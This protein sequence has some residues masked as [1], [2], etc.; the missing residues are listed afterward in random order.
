MIPANK[1][2]WFDALFAAYVRSKLR[3]T[4]HTV[5]V[6]GA[7][8][9]RTLG[10]QAPLLLVSNHT[11]WW[12]PLI[13]IALSRFALDVDGHAMMDAKNLAKLPFFRRVGAFGVDRD[14]PQDG[15]R[16]IRYAAKL[17]D[18]PR[19]MVWIFAQGRERPVTERPLV[20]F[21][22]AAETARIARR[23]AVVPVALR[24]EHGEAP[25]PSVWVSFGESIVRA[26]ERETEL[27]RRSHEEAVTRELDRIDEAIRAESREGFAPLWPTRRSV[28]FETAQRALALLTGR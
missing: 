8:K 22:G 27:T 24:Y 20:F 16:A 15:A 17:L 21:G 10:A 26:R 5:L 13:A 4:F 3:R 25:E 12:D 9:A 6:R 18:R 11:A 7:D 28:V 23:A 14:D 1:T 19:R 2:P